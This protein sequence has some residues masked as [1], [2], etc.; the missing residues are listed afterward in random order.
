MIGLFL[1]VLGE[2]VIEQATGALVQ[3]GGN[4]AAIGDKQ[5]VTNSRKI[6]LRRKS[7]EGWAVVRLVNEKRPPPYRSST[8]LSR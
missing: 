1:R 4:G 6:T 3:A 2:P 8:R 7:S 5:P